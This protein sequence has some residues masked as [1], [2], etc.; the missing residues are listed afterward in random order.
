MP[1]QELG[2]GPVPSATPAVGGKRKWPQ[3][4][5]IWSR[6]GKMFIFR[7]ARHWNRVPKEWGIPG[8]VQD[9]SGCGAG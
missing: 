5:E 6:L 2:V 3:K 4:G 1:G 7:V 9:V 8:G